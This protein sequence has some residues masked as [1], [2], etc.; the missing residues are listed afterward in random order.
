MHRRP[1]YTPRVNRKDVVTL[2]AGAATAT[3]AG[4]AYSIGAPTL[5]QFAAAAIALAILAMLIGEAT[6]QL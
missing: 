2:V 1:P 5:V 4:V 6:N 3:A